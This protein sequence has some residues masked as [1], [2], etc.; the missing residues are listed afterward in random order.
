M[1][2]VRYYYIFMYMPISYYNP[3][4]N[5]IDASCIV[6]IVSVNRNELQIIIIIV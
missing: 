1:K 2:N 6:T 4:N 3:G 5:F